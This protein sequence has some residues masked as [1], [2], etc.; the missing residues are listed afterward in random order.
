MLKKLAAAFLFC[1][2]GAAAFAQNAPKKPFASYRSG[3]QLTLFYKQSCPDH[4]D[5]GNVWSWSETHLPGDTVIPGCWTEYR[6]PSGAAAKVKLCAGGPNAREKWE[7]SRDESDCIVGEAHEVFRELPDPEHA[8]AAPPPPGDRSG[9]TSQAK[10]PSKANPNILANTNRRD[11]GKIL[12][13]ASPCSRLAEQGMA[14]I[15][16]MAGYVVLSE[17]AAGKTI[18]VGCG[19]SRAGV[20]AVKWLKEEDQTYFTSSDL[21]LGEADSKPGQ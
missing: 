15:G 3:N 11:G 6:S 12:F 18:N 20:T 21:K 7:M 19:E 16:S 2:I 17:N 5:D 4:R 10:A 14:S 13:T 9:N 8:L 1:A